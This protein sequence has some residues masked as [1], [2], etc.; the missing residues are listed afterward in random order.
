MILKYLLLVVL[1][2]FIVRASGN[3]MRAVRGGLNPPPPQQRFDPRG[4]SGPSNG[5]SSPDRSN[6]RSE[7]EGDGF[8][9]KDIEDATWEDLD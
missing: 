9:G 2:Y 3:L 5:A 7:D 8:W 4:A 1:F 6:P